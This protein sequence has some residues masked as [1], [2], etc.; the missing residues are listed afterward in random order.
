MKLDL[1]QEDTQLKNDTKW[2]L[3]K[4]SLI[5]QDETSK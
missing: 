1:S 5:R 3:R 4:K 2:K